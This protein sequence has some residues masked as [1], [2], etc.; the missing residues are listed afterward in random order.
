MKPIRIVLI[1]YSKTNKMAHKD[2]WVNCI[3]TESIKGESEKVVVLKVRSLKFTRKEI[4]RKYNSFLLRNLALK[5]QTEIR[6]VWNST[7]HLCQ[8]LQI[9]L[10]KLKKILLKSQVFEVRKYWRYLNLNFWLKWSAVMYP[11][12]FSIQKINSNF[13]KNEH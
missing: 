11:N 13:G 12:T 10:A 2:F 3:K 1:A 7:I 9:F 6:V 4:T 8:F 5:D